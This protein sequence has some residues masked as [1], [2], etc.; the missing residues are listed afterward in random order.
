M[1][2]ALDSLQQKVTRVATRCRELHAENAALREQL[3]ALA[4]ER[5]ALRDRLAAAKSRIERLLA[6][7]PEA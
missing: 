5:D 6:K 1:E 2:A 3:A 7:L 4:G